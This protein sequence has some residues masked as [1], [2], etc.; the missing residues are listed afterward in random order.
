MWSTL[1]R[2]SGVQLGHDKRDIP[3]FD[4]N[5]FHSNLSSLQGKFLSDVQTDKMVLSWDKKYQRAL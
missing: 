1:K 2:S 5:F 3:A 4:T